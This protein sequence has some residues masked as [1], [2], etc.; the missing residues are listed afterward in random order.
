MANEPCYVNACEDPKSRSIYYHYGLDF[1]GCEGLAE[2]T[3]ATDGLIASV[4]KQVLPGYEDTPVRTRYDVV[5]V[6]DA[7]GWFY[8]YSHLFSIDKS[9]R[10]G[11]RIRRGQPIGLLGK[12]G[13]SGGW[14][15]LHFD[16]Q[17][18]MPSGEWGCLE[19]YAFAWEAYLDQYR[20][21]LI[22]V[23]RPH[24][25]I[26]TGETIVLDASRSWSAESRI[27]SY[28]WT[29]ADGTTAPG[30]RLKRTYDRPGY[31]S[32]ILKVTDAEGR[33]EYDFAIVHVLDRERSDSVPPTIHAAYHPTLGIQ[34]G[35]EITFKVRT[36]A[37]TD[38]VEKWDFG[39]GTAGVETQSDGCVKKLAKDGYA[40]TTHAYGKPG[41]YIVCVQRTDRFGRTAIDH[42]CV[43]VGE[44]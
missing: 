1:G 12:E 2:V 40:V 9:L 15:H 24:H 39:D 23:A 34:P 38:G 16:I 36:F 42:V 13:G 10:P 44:P 33:V 29:F 35:Q 37:T 14:T 7:R 43:R 22:A 25:T 27:T 17:C 31:Y 32:E 4:G 26:W 20:P 30:R 8:R 28:E 5:Y 6:V 18:R 21:Q 19:S 3:A 41:K 11:E